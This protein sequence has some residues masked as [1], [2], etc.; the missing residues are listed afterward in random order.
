MSRAGSVFS[1]KLICLC[2][3]IHKSICRLASDSDRVWNPRYTLNRNDKGERYLKN[4][5]A[6]SSVNILTAVGFEDHFGG[7]A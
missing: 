5:D 2:E 4:I 6:S 1:Y 3:I 7:G